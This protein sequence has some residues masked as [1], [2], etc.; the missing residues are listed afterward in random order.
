MFLIRLLR[1]L[2]GYVYFKAYGGFG[3]RFLNL[4]SVYGIPLWDVTTIGED[5]YAATTVQGYKNI[6]I[7]AK[8]SGM[9]TKS[10]KRVGLP[11]LLFRFRHRTGIA[12]GLAIFVTCLMFLSCR[13]W[14]I[15]VEGN[16]LVPEEAIIQAV[17]NAGLYIGSAKSAERA[18]RISVSAGSEI[19]EIAALSVNYEGAV[20]LVKVKERADEPII[21]NKDGYFNLVSTADAQLVVLEPYSGDVRAKLFNP[22]FK[23]DVLI[24]GVAK[25]KDESVRY[26]HAS[27]YAVGRTDKKISAQ[28]STEEKLYCTEKIKRVYS[29]YL[30]GAEI[31]LGKPPEKYDSAFICSKNLCYN[32]RKM[33]IG[34]SFAEYSAVEDSPQTLSKK[35]AQMISI[36]RFVSAA[37]DYTNSRQVIYQKAHSNFSE[38]NC[39]VEGEFACY[40]NIGQELPFEIEEGSQ[41]E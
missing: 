39:V 6:R 14:V 18:A 21:E 10:V 40:E 27:G 37:E 25:N 31:P 12:I 22:V 17:E 34:I 8:K 13:V 24:S 23:G 19:E 41:P 15:E 30:F 4:C 20:A 35:E 36:A 26:C 28:A 7:C 9:K 33:P 1:L 5:V 2:S 32:K 11:F 29:L 16:N 38:N 3:E